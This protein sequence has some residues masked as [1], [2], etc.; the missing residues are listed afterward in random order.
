MIL[1]LFRAL[2]YFRL[3]ESKISFLVPKLWP[4]L[5]SALDKD[6]YSKP[7]REKHNVHIDKCSV[8]FSASAWARE[9]CGITKAFK[10]DK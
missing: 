9:A 1:V 5:F 3:A 6:G 2:R 7:M 8:L 10:L 4:R